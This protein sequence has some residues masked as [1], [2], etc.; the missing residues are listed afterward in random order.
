MLLVSM[1]SLVTILTFFFGIWLVS[2]KAR[3]ASIIDMFWG[4]GFVVI[5]WIAFFTGS[6]ATP[7]RQLMVAM[8]TLWGLRL[9]G[10][11]A[12]RNWGKDE[13]YRYQAMRKQHG[14]RFPIVSL[15][16]V[17]MLQ[18]VVLWI[19]SL[20]VQAAQVYP[21]PKDLGI[22]DFIGLGVFAIG[23][24]FESVGDAQLAR[25]KA[26]PSN[27]GKVMNRGLWRY[28]RHPNYFGDFMV[29]WGIYFVAL[30]TF[31]GFWTIIGP[32]LM[33]FFLMRVSGVPLLEKSLR[34]NRPDYETYIQQTSAFFP[35]PP[36]HRA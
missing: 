15:Y 25:F 16:R 4:L 1:Y 29:W 34:K 22:L 3:D 18:A 11:L 32:A 26:D 23:L 36:K 8:V 28:T 21:D 14:D 7:R 13:D 19:V 33:S 9:S 2:L 6:G 17:F 20:P 30:A 5:A 12:R 27:A 31:S 35:R 24:F 10:Y